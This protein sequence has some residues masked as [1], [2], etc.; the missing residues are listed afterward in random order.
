VVSKVESEVQI[1]PLDNTLLWSAQALRNKIRL[2]IFQILSTRN[3]CSFNELMKNLNISQP[4]LAYHL[5]K[6]V[7]FNIITNFYDKRQGVKDHSF[8]ALSD[9]GRDLISRITISSQLSLTPN[10]NQ[11][12]NKEMLEFS[13][14]RSLRHLEYKSYEKSTLKRS[15]N[16]LEEVK[17][18]NRIRYD[19]LLNCHIITQPTGQNSTQKV[20][21]P[22]FRKYYSSYKNPFV[23]K[24]KG[25]E[26]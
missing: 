15:K 1:N 11:K 3:S 8:Y 5:Q 18:E 21:I 9:F 13:N 19:H 22:S 25:D 23:T 24:Q 26:K 14:F 17:S 2:Q 20:E 4:K 16:S 6:L 12:E 7:K 10:E